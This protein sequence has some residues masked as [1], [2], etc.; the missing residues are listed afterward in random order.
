MKQKT[1]KL[2]KKNRKQQNRGIEQKTAKT[3][4]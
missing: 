4:E 2:E 1:V 3:G